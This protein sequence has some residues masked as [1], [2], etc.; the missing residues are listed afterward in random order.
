MPLGGAPPG[1]KKRSIGEK[2]MDAP[3]LGVSDINGA[4]GVHRDPRRVAHTRVLKRKQ[5]SATRFKFVNEARA[6]VGKENVALR[7]GCEC[8]W[9]IELARA[10]AFISP[11]AEEF[12]R[13]RRL[14]F[15]RRIRAISAR[16]EE[17]YRSQ[18][19]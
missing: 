11:S 1:L 15:R 10:I 6:R 13:R 5:G 3:P 7:I 4:A 8:H 17:K 18:R 2:E 9:L 16:N 14:R 12:K 19:G